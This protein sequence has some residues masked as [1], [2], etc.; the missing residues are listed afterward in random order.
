MGDCKNASISWCFSVHLP[1]WL[2]SRITKQT[3][4]KRQKKTIF[5]KV[6]HGGNIGTPCRVD[7]ATFLWLGPWKPRVEKLRFGNIGEKSGDSW[8]GQSSWVSLASWAEGRSI[9]ETK[10]HQHGNLKFLGEFQPLDFLGVRVVNTFITS[11]SCEKS[12]QK[13]FKGM[14]FDK[15]VHL[16]RNIFI[17]APQPK[18]NHW[19]NTSRERAF[20]GRNFWGAWEAPQLKRATPGTPSYKFTTRV[21]RHWGQNSV[22][23]TCMQTKHPIGTKKHVKKKFSCTVYICMHT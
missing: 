19:E 4:P 1:R 16:S 22:H 2:Q 20:Q 8:W 9:T 15:F 14:D 12:V 10:T 23:V 13:F 17:F 18:V 6:A 3:D 7:G 5:N 11:G 21:P